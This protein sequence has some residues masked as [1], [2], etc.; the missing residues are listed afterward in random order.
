MK[1][2]STSI[3][4]G[5]AFLAVCALVGCTH[6][7]P[8][9]PTMQQGNGAIKG[10]LVDGTGEP[11]DVSLAGDAGAK[12]LQI[13]L[14]SSTAGVV[15]TTTPGLRKGE[16]VFNNVPPGRYELT[17]YDVV[18]D[19]RTVAGNQTVTVDPDQTTSATMTL[20]VSEQK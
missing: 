6:D 2:S 11:F 7:S 20:Q 3:R 10:K 17:V 12:A 4:F 13:Q 8:S 18:P 5:I 14:I 19:K 16:F 1:Q 9:K 15:A